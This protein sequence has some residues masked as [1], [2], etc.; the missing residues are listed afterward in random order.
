MPEPAPVLGAAQIAATA[1]WIAT[2][3]EPD[4]AL[5]WFRGG[6][7][8]PWDHVEAAMGLSAAGLLAEAEAAYAWSAGTQR[9]DGSWPML[10][11]AGE[12]QDPAADTNQCAY[13]AVGVWHHYLVT[14]DSGFLARMW[15]TVQRALDFVVSAQ[16]G[17]GSL[18][19]AVNRHGIPDSYSLLTGSAS[20]VQALRCGSLIAGE[21]GIQSLRWPAAADRLAHAVRLHPESFAD[22]SRY[23]MDW[24]YPV[25][26]G[27]VRGGDALGMLARRWAEFVWP[28]RGVRCVSDRPW[29]TVA[30]SCEL[31]L[32][33]DSLGRHDMA[34][35]VLADVQSMRADSGGYW[36][37]YV[38][39]DDAIWPEEQTTWT[40]AA[41]ILAADALH[42]AGGGH[43]LFRSVV[44]AP[45]AGDDDCGCL[46]DELETVG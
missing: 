38:V 19:W 22:R 13:I 12:I 37:G 42:G 30:E 43:G 18:A 45:D 32:A 25:L 44:S 46:E 4:G 27:V 5:P 35:A 29:V 28:G 2:Q 33:L 11:R 17:D 9:A 15:P 3:Q 40:S 16:R 23:S 24:Y 31:V 8:D 10:L 26:G 41:V 39:D 6:Q 7:L 14:G 34:R 1:R 36:T 20:A 21:R